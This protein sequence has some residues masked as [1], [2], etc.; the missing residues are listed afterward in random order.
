MSASYNEIMETIKNNRMKKREGFTNKSPNNIAKKRSSQK[1]KVKS[2]SKDL[3]WAHFVAQTIHIIVYFWIFFPF[4]SYQLQIIIDQANCGPPADNRFGVPAQ[5][6]HGCSLPWQKQEGQTPTPYAPTLNAKSHVKPVH[7]IE[8]TEKEFWKIYHFIVKCIY[9]FIH[10]LKKLFRKAESGA[11]DIGV[12][13]ATVE[14]PVLA[15][16]G[17]LGGD[18][19]KK[20]LKQ[21]AGLIPPKS[22]SAGASGSAFKS[23]GAAGAAE[24]AAAKMFGGAYIEEAAATTK[25]YKITSQDIA[26]TTGLLDSKLDQLFRSGIPPGKKAKRVWASKLAETVGKAACCRN[27]KKQLDPDQLA[28]CDKK[29]FKSPFSWMFDMKKFGWPYDYIFDS[30]AVKVYMKTKGRN[31]SPPK[32][33]NPHL[34]HI[35]GIAVD[36]SANYTYSLKSWKAWI[37]AWFAETQLKSWSRNRWLMHTF[38]YLFYPFLNRP[39]TADMVH[40][41]YDNMINDIAEMLH[42]VHTILHPEQGT[43]DAQKKKK[44]TNIKAGLEK[45]QNILRQNKLTF[46]KKCHHHCDIKTVLFE[47]LKGYMHQEVSAIKAYQQ[48]VKGKGPKPPNSFFIEFY[49]AALKPLSLRQY[50]GKSV[51]WKWC[52]PA[53]LDPEGAGFFY[54]GRYLVTL[55][56]PYLM[57][58]QMYG[59]FFLSIIQTFIA[60]FNRYSIFWLPLAFAFIPIIL[61]MFA[62]P[63]EA[64]YY[65]LIG[66]SGSRNDSAACPYTGGMHQL[67][68]NIHTYW[69]LNLFICLGSI[70]T[71]LGGTLLATKTGPPALGGVLTAIFPVLIIVRLLVGFVRWLISLFKSA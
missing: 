37:M 45:Y 59:S 64:L 6:Q 19:L 12:D 14:D 49:M 7:I 53:L 2:G 44:Y 55:C 71:H 38:L 60:L 16:P 27:L 13:L 42:K 34:E 52:E 3:V 28:D 67:K 39:L 54:W 63:M 35:D 11:I 29:T 23:T 62:M 15:A 48:T 47:T 43:V 24:A 25:S 58:T 70:I 50:K 4:W 57:S 22:A 1:E 41:H 51:W 30:E 31:G 66:P 9:W 40:T 20:K 65:L 46:R 33:Y 8:Q 10:A 21:S 69:P 61:N 68:E 32:A 26:S 18:A 17:P 5:P 36:P 56:M